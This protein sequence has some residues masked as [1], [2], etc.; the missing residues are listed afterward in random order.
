VAALCES[1][2]LPSGAVGLVLVN[3]V[4][5]DASTVLR[6]GDEVSLFAPVGGG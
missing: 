6:D 1:L 5:G 4:H 2:G 3:G